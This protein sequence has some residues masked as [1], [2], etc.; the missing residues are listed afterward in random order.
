[1][2]LLGMKSLLGCYIQCP[3]QDRNEVRIRP[4]LACHALDMGLAEE[5]PCMKQTVIEF[6]SFKKIACG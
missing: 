6:W 4:F 1:M 5:N 2:S 3:I